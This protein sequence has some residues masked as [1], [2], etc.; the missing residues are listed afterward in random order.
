MS[1]LNTRNWDEFHGRMLRGEWIA[2]AVMLA[3][4]ALV[5]AGLTFGSLQ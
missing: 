1:R 3:F 4:Q 5:V 2:G